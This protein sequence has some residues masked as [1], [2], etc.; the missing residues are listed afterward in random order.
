MLPKPLTKR[1][2]DL[3]QAICS[4]EMVLVTGAA[5]TGKSFLPA[6][7]AAY[8]YHI[9]QVDKII[10]TRPT[11]PVGKGLGFLPG[12]L[13][14]KLEP[15]VMPFIAVMEQFLSK[16]E[17]D[18]MIKNG[19]LECVPFDVIRGRTFNDSFIVLDEGQNTTIAEMK[20][21][22]TRVGQRSKVVINGD[23]NQSDLK[24]NEKSGLAYLCYLLDDVNNEKLAEKVAR[25][26]FQIEDCVRGDLCRLWLEAFENE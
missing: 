25:V 9:N 15:W 4:K 16:G 12:D 18:C 3:I 17:I 10:L 5:G 13:M 14:E 1:Q 11:V 8:F 22:V 23:C 7:Y 21:F 26:D 24:L 6:A 19:K 2:N 20:A